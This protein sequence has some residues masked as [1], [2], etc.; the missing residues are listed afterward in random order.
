MKLEDQIRKVIRFKHYRMRTEGSY[1]G[2]Y[3]PFVK[4]HMM[5]HPTEL[6]VAAVEGF[7]THPAGRS[8]GQYL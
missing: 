6:G 7:L 3:K 8:P 2:W 1:V 4:F 5:R